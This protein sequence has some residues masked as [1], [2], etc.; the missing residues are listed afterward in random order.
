MKVF[1]YVVDVD[2]RWHQVDN[3]L[4]RMKISGDFSA[5]ARSGKCAS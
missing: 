4:S 3:E 1:K 5:P 2:D